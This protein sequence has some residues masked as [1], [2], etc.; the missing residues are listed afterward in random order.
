MT[1]HAPRLT[2]LIRASTPLPIAVNPKPPHFS[3][4]P[5]CV[6]KANN[7]RGRCFASRLCVPHSPAARPRARVVARLLS[8]HCSSRFALPHLCCRG[9]CVQ[10]QFAHFI[11][12]RVLS[13][14]LAL[15]A[16]LALSLLVA[17]PVA[18]SRAAEDEL[19]DAV[20]QDLSAL[21]EVEAEAA[22]DEEAPPAFPA[23]NTAATDRC[24]GDDCPGALNQSG[25]SVQGSHD[26]PVEAAAAGSARDGPLRAG[27]QGDH[28]G[29]AGGVNGPW[30]PSD[31]GLPMAGEQSGEGSLFRATPAKRPEDI[32]DCVACRYIWL[33]IEEAVGNTAVE[34]AVFD[35]FSNS[36]KDAAAAPMFFP[37]CSDMFAQADD[38]IG[39]YMDGYTVNQVCE[40]A[41]L[42]R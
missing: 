39:D 10:H 25:A 40:N 24:T 11:I 41:R 32:E 1:V 35:A 28:V 42:C 29:S 8:D 7:R 12:M 14:T 2:Q 38:M 17:S 20:E 4:S 27:L 31:A 3:F 19:A 13:L 16:L 18:A 23:A 36:C 37:A 30:I 9:R 26:G 34:E 21:V 33:Q 22:A 6:S 5:S 15:L